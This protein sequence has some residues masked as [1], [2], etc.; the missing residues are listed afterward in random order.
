M[1]IMS[2]HQY[3]RIQQLAETPSKVFNES[4]KI[5]LNKDRLIF[6]IQYPN[7]KIYE[8]KALFDPFSGVEAK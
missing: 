4:A 7:E 8:L 5:P 1:H 3:V 2:V 6:V